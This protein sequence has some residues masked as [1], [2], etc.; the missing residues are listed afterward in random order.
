MKSEFIRDVNMKG[1]W[2]VD[3]TEAIKK[4]KLRQKYDEIWEKIKKDNNW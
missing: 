3:F 2:E 1:G 4:M